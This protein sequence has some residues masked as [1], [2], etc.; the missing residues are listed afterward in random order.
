MK[1]N[2]PTEPSDDSERQ[3][4]DLDPSEWAGMPPPQS[5]PPPSPPPLDEAFSALLSSAANSSRTFSCASRANDKP[6][7]P[8]GVSSQLVAA[9][10]A[11][12]NNHQM[13]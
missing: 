9:S 5:P 1:H 4:L 2:L 12:L 3:A 8:Q 13:L 10:K 11:S 7:H 6:F